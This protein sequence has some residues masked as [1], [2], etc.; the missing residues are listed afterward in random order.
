MGREITPTFFGGESN[1]GIQ[2]LGTTTEK[3]WDIS[4][5]T[6]LLGLRDIIKEL[7][8]R[9]SRLE[10]L[11]RRISEF[12]NPRVVPVLDSD[13]EFIS[14]KGKELLRVASMRGREV[15]KQRRGRDSKF[16]DLAIIFKG[17]EC[18]FN[19]DG[20]FYIHTPTT[21]SAAD[22]LLK[23]L[24]PGLGLAID[25]AYPAVLDRVSKGLENH[26]TIVDPSGDW[27]EFATT[28]PGM[29]LSYFF[30]DRDRLR[31]T[32]SVQVNLSNGVAMP[33]EGIF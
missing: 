26:L 13:E 29:T 16:V 28:V 32:V 12:T 6:R 1:R 10:D 33:L 17:S 23:I 20:S 2:P 31:R 9:S 27:I 11:R 25:Q 22:G 21:L 19:I 15:I 8:G 14:L 3:A 7:G 18:S 30:N 24:T 5:T 4:R